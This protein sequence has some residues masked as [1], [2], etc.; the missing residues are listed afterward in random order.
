MDPLSD[1][2]SDSDDERVIDFELSFSD[3]ETTKEK[4]RPLKTYRVQY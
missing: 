4:V 1:V 3:D 2:V